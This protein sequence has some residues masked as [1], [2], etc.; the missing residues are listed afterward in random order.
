LAIFQG[1]FQGDSQAIVGA[2]TGA[3]LGAPIGRSPP[4]PFTANGRSP[5]PFVRYQ[6]TM[7]A[8]EACARLRRLSTVSELSE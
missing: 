7:A 6:R 4:P 8:A 5:P 1:D 2:I 3:G